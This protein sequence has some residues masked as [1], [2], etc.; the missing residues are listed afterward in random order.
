MEIVT[1]QAPDASPDQQF[2]YT[3]QLFIPGSIQTTHSLQEAGVEVENS[4]P[5]NSYQQMFRIIE[6]LKVVVL[7]RN[8]AQHEMA[9]G[10]FETMYLLA[11]AADYRAGRSESRLMRIGS[12]A[13]LLAR[14]ANQPGD[15]C[16]RIRL[17]A[18]LHD[19]GMAAIPDALLRKKRELTGEEWVLW[20]NH[21]DVGARML[22]AVAT[23]VL[24]L[25]AEIALT[26]HENYQGHGYPVGLADMQIPLSG[27]I[28]AL[29]EYFE[30]YTDE[31]TLHQAMMPPEVVLASIRERSGRRFDPALVEL[32]FAN[33]QTI[34]DARKSIEF[35]N[36]SLQARVSNV[37]A[38]AL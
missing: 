34:C 11:L 15:Y 26:H 28:V 12:T 27:R 31:F 35:S 23:P 36:G 18:P 6:D 2:I 3:D 37:L 4:G 17:A 7:Q 32:F 20:R 38:H 1:A 10:Y 5:G 33:L 9:E 8:E 29:A 30:T 13:E 21:T 14:A 22:G 24:Q 25:A 19:I 16:S